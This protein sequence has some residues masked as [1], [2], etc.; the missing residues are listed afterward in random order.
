MRT[1]KHERHAGPA[2]GEVDEEWDA[3]AATDG[4]AELV[5]I[6]C[7]DCAQ[8][9]AC[10]DVDEPLPIHALCPTR[11]DPFGLTVCAGSG[12]VVGDGAG[13]RSVATAQRGGEATTR[14]T[15][16]EGLDWRLQPFSDVGRVRQAA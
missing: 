2:G 14:R 6:T 3:E 1:V 11:W 8:P 5:R 16:P 12:R 13:I 9:I 7:P 10:A 15:L 4:D